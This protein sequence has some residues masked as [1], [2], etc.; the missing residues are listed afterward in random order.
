M[1]LRSP[2]PGGH[3]LCMMSRFA[4]FDVAPALR[5]ALAATGFERPLPVQADAIPPALAGRDVV[6]SAETGSGKTL[7]YLVPVA[8]RLLSTATGTATGTGAGDGRPRALVLAPTRELAIQ[9]ASV[10]DALLAPPGLRCARLT[11]GEPV[12]IQARV[13]AAGCDLVIATPGR[14]L[15]HARRGNL[16][17]DAIRTV[18]LDEADRMLDLGFLP[19]V[20]RCLALVPPPR[21]TLLYSATIPAAIEELAA[22]LL[23]DPV[24]VRAAA[25]DDRP[26]PPGIRHQVSIVRAPLKRLLLAHLLQR[27]DVRTALV[28]T[29]SRFRCGALARWLNEVGVAAESL[30]AGRKQEDRDAALTGFRESRLRVLVAT[31]LAERGLDLPNLTHVIIFDLPRRP[32][33][34][35]HRV[36]RTA[37]AFGEGTAITLAAP[38][39]RKHTAKLAARV[40]VEVEIVTF[41][42]FDYDQRPTGLDPMGPQNRGQQ[43]DDES[44]EARAARPRRR[45]TSPERQKAAFWER[46]RNARK[47][48]APRNPNPAKRRRGR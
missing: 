16:R 20:R 21:Q 28:F 40:G 5:E 42:G 11:G 24:R 36:G 44:E 23:D 8:H 38:P 19:H 31:D 3:N 48:Q 4:A 15:D 7:A 34:Y 43:R 41:D 22:E 12:R 17:A 30:H 32:E 47:K 39:E 10:A 29:S 27:D 9:V 2:P 45:R 13:L 14:L 46:A 1:P 33:T 18:V 26:I 35:A 6:V 37:R 25:D